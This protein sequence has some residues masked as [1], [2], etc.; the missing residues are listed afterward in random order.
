M[1]VTVNIANKFN[2]GKYEKM[3]FF[4][5]NKKKK[6]ENFINLEHSYKHQ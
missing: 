5:Y 6:M 3:N 4:S 2:V 1:Y